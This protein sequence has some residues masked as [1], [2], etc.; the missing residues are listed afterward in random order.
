MYMYRSL[1]SPPPPSLP[2]EV[3]Q[4]VEQSADQGVGLASDD[5]TCHL[6]WLSYG[7]KQVT[8]AQN[9]NIGVQQHVHVHVHGYTMYIVYLQCILY[10]YMYIYMYIYIHVHCII[11]VIDKM[12]HGLCNY[13]VGKSD[14]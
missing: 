5:G 4:E 8:V 14:L 1:L 3:G 13:F 10:M 6:Q 2:D 11:H 9:V 7:S 12:L